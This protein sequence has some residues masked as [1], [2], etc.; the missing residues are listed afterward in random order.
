MADLFE[1][2]GIEQEVLD[3]IGEQTAGSGLIKPGVH[4]IEVEELFLRETDSGAKMLHINGKT[5]EGKKL[6][7]STCVLSKKGKTTYTRKTKKGD[8]EIPLPGVEE[9]KRLMSALEIEKPSLKDTKV[10]WKDGEISV[11]AIPDAIGK[12]IKVGVKI[13]EGGEYSD[14]NIITAYMKMDGTNGKGEAVEE[15]IAANIA[16]NP[17]KKLKGSDNNAG[18]ATGGSED[19]AADGWA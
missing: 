7:Y 15:D 2:L 9:S 16:R 18:Q 13:E 17:I 3:N 14:K 5:K 11:K 8:K 19:A 12:R 6:Y 10:E 1:E 4:A